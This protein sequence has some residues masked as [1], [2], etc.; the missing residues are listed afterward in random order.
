MK[1]ETRNTM[2]TEEIQWSYDLQFRFLKGFAESSGIDSNEVWDQW[3]GFSR[4]LP[5][6][7]R[8]RIE[9]G[10]YESGLAEGTKFRKMYLE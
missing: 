5:G 2:K 10:G 3:A 1:T 7:E 9:S 6:H 8:D 4:D